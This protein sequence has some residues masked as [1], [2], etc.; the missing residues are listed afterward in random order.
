MDVTN[1]LQ[2]TI[3]RQMLQTNVLYS[4]KE[5]GIAFEYPR[6]WEVVDRRNEYLHICPPER[7][8][9]RYADANCIY[10]L[11]GDSIQERL[12][13][14]EE[15]N[16]IMAAFPEI[17]ETATVYSELRKMHYNVEK[18]HPVQYDLSIDLA[19]LYQKPQNRR[20]GIWQTICR[21]G[22]RLK[23]IDIFNHVLNSLEWFP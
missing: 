21:A 12:N 14:F 2:S 16:P 23:C 18:R 17:F 9:A 8:D 11:F 13:D 10:F 20:V 15:G 3:K 7:I 5:R 6:E 19:G 1:R 22:D 4:S